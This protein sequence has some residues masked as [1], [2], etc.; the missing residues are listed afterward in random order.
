MV[1]KTKKTLDRKVECKFCKK[2]VKRQTA[3]RKHVIKFHI[4]EVPMGHKPKLEQWY[5][6]ID[7]E[8]EYEFCGIKSTQDIDTECGTGPLV[9]VKYKEQNGTST[10][11]THL[12]EIHES[13]IWTKYITKAAI[14]SFRFRVFDF[15]FLISSFRFRVFDF[16]F[17]FSISSF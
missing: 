8:E 3:L 1:P 12:R 6:E 14:S 7:S 9:N 17:E 5:N 11:L 15:E 10:S 13:S 4:N 2:H 16:D